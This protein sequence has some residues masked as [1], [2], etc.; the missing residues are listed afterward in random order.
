MFSTGIGSAVGA[1]LYSRGAS[2]AL[3]DVIPQEAG[4]KVAAALTG[5]EGK[6]I[7]VQADITDSDKCKTAVASVVVKLGNLVGLVHCAGIAIKRK[8]SNVVSASTGDLEKMFKG[9]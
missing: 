9:G 3:F 8:W 6:A 2:V 5:G 7:Y 1:D 4:D